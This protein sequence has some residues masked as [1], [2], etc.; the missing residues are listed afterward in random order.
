MRLLLSIAFSLLFSAIQIRSFFDLSVLSIDNLFI[1][2]RMRLLLAAV[3]SLLA[4]SCYAAASASLECGG[5]CYYTIHYFITY[6]F[7]AWAHDIWSVCCSG[8]CY[9]SN[10]N[11]LRWLCRSYE[12]LTS[13]YILTLGWSSALIVSVDRHGCAHP[14]IENDATEWVHPWKL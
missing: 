14:V 7:L 10:S 2:Y 8:F 12:T 9:V 11:W 1:D 5:E 13:R 6:F 3:V 4:A